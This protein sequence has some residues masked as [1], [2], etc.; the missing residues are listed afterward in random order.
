MNSKNLENFESNILD[1]INDILN[2]KAL[3]E[4]EIEKAIFPTITSCVSEMSY[5]ERKFLNGVIRKVRPKKILELGVSAGGSSAIIL[6]AIKDIKEAKLYSIDYSTNYCKCYTKK[7][8]F[9]IDE[10]FTSLKDKWSLYTGGVAAKFLDKIGND[11]DLCLLDTAHINPGEFLD[12]LMVLPYLKKNA[13]VIL[14]DTIFHLY[15]E[16]YTNGVLFAAIKGQKIMPYEGEVKNI[17]NIGAII[18]DDDIM[19]YIFD[20]FYLLTLRWNYLP[21][22]EDLDYIYKLFNKFYDNTLVELYSSIVDRNR[23]LFSTAISSVEDIYS[24]MFPKKEINNID[25]TVDKI[26]WWI[27]V[28]KWRESF[29]AKFKVRPDQTRPDQTRPDQTRPDQ[30]RPNSNM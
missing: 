21:T 6:N 9:I 26:A 17:A 24:T 12:F 14:H 20:Y 11:I 10:K 19:N 30:T 16:G 23:R 8:G 5:L 3:D 15:R 2:M 4:I 25:T 18:L 22:D 7:T 1:E 13:I 29:R 27:P 28:K